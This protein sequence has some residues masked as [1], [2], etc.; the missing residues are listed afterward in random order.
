[1]VTTTAKFLLKVLTGLLVVVV[2]IIG[3]GSFAISR[4]PVSI[5][6][7]SEYI[8]D[9]LAR[10]YPGQ[11]VEFSDLV[12]EWAS[13]DRELHVRAK[14]V[15]VTLNGKRIAAIPDV[16]SRFSGDA[17]L[18]G[19]LAPSELEFYGVRILVTRLAS[20]KF[21]VGYSTHRSDDAAEEGAAGN[22]ALSAII[23]ELSE[24]PD[25]SR[26]TGYLKRLEMYDTEI[27]FND[28]KRSK[29]WQSTA[30]VL[31]ISRTDG[32]MQGA[33]ALSVNLHGHP[34][35]VE[36]DVDYQRENRKIV[37]SIAVADIP[38]PLLAKE[39]SALE[40]LKDADLTVSGDVD[41]ALSEHFDLEYV[42]FAARSGAGS[43][44]HPD[45]YKKPLA[46]SAAK[47]EG[48][49]N[50]DMSELDLTRID[51]DFGGPTLKAGG[52][53]LLSDSSP[54]L[55]FSG[56]VKNFPTNEL[57]NFWPHTM[58]VDGYNWVTKNIRD[59]K[60]TSGEFRIDLPPGAIESGR[61]PKDA[62][63]LAFD[64]EGLSTNYYAP[65]PPVT[66]ISGSAVLSERQIHLT[67]MTGELGGM[68]V[69]EGDA[70]IGGFHLKDQ[71]ATIG[72]VISGSSRQIM[73]FLDRKPLEFISP[74]GIVPALVSGDAAVRAKFAFPLLDRL[75]LPDVNF[76]AAARLENTAIPAVA[77]DV[78]LSDGQLIV[79]VEPGGFTAH[80]TA[81]LNDIPSKIDVQ[82]WFK[83][84]NKGVRKYHIETVLTREHRK[85][86]AIDSDRLLG[87][88]SIT[89]D[90]LDRNDGGIS[91]ALSAD[92][93]GA[94][95]NVPALKWRKQAM[96]PA[97]LKTV[98]KVDAAR[99]I[100]LDNT[101][102]SSADLSATG[103]LRIEDGALKQLF[104]SKVKWGLSDFTASYVDQGA[105]NIDVQIKGAAFDMKPFVADLGVSDAEAAVEP[106]TEQSRTRYLVQAEFARVILDEDVNITSVKASLEIK[107]EE[108]RAGSVTGQIKGGAPL[109]MRVKPKADKRVVSI[110]SDDAGAVL[111]A[112]D[113]YD[114]VRGGKMKIRAII[115]D[116]AANKPTRG[117]VEMSDIKVVN[118]P[119]LAKIL[120]V[121]SLQGIAD[122]LSGKGATFT[123]IDAP[124]KYA[125]GVIT[126]KD[127]RA[128]GSV[129]LTLNGTINRKS[130]TIDAFGTVIPSYTINSV[131]GNIPILGRLLVGREGEG[132]F[133]FSYK[134]KG[135]VGDPDVSV[136]PLSAFAPGIL[137]RMLFEPFEGENKSSV[138]R[139]LEEYPEAD[140]ERQ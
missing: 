116:S 113:I 29:I 19:K 118:A 99:N 133:A 7:L 67:G 22:D 15:F 91:G 12:L 86:L 105:G 41:F 135:P 58:A 75:E 136:N 35:Q 43:Y 134:V 61:I 44:F 9:I 132:I 94:E 88:A 60:V 137:R 138:D 98:F 130:D 52:K 110:F 3:I 20:G 23:S 104:L 4:G 93:S 36:A 129:G 74:Y 47:V 109:V 103:A 49:L 77:K 106:D 28:E 10:Q 89:A 102:F 56:D 26:A 78:D 40:I 72:A 97:A 92:L 96:L 127:F 51:V 31:V 6:F 80:G 14:D 42:T 25:K 48:S 33:L 76:A 64:F 79:D 125:D 101:E 1:M 45:L 84:Q 111:Q 32:G 70:L 107:D 115:D 39:H 30:K 66:N 11:K 55:Q 18:D 131:L 140:M 59:G 126:V 2:V 62:V 108:I 100:Q 5:G 16:S 17:L 95:I 73:T 21:E 85:K 24:K 119:M 114:N 83:G 124:F 122:L 65:L 54:G 57:G 13:H 71:S 38:L 128:V 139:I 53:V 82:S 121:A 117:A 27:M 46:I 50:S 81:S 37:A 123:K 69:S 112:F 34:L 120:Q 90:I 8:V 87:P 63:R 68:T